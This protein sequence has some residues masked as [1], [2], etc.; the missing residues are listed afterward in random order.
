[1]IRM[2]A[3]AAAL[4]GNGLVSAAD[5]IIGLSADAQSAVF[6]RAV[7]E[8]II[9]DPHTIQFKTAQPYPNLPVDMSV[10]PMLSKRAVQNA[11]SPDFDAGKAAIGTGPYKLVRFARGDRIE[12]QRHDAYRGPKPAWDRVAIR[13]ITNAG[14][15]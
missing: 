8:K 13:I 4:L 1:M 7:R 5:V 14:R 12:L 6:T 3:L 11:Q 15:G 2:A 10:L 9:V